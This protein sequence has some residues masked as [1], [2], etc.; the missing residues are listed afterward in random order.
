MSPF[1]KLVDKCWLVN[2]HHCTCVAEEIL[3]TILLL[4][5]FTTKV[6]FVHMEANVFK[7]NV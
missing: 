2:D 1:P 7:T 4:L 3:P 6:F 5:L